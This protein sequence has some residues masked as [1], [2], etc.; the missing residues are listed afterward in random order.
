MMNTK[1]FF[2]A[3]FIAISF[4]V[5]AVFSGGCMGNADKNDEKSATVIDNTSASKPAQ[6]DTLAKN[7]SAEKKVAEKTVV[8][9]KTVEKKTNIFDT[10]AKKKVQSAASGAAAIIQLTDQ[11]FDATTAGGFTFV[12]FWATW[13]RPC[14]MQGPIVEEVNTAMAGK[15]KFCKLDIDKNKESARKY[16]VMNIPTMIIFKNGKEV[17]R[18][19]GLTQKDALITTI[20][21]QLN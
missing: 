8:V 9:E 20:N 13:C 4:S 17:K 21:E 3:N 14:M 12:D 6:T 10:T 15:L 7:L 19:V 1:Q 5:V 18:I 16:N 11:T 2:T